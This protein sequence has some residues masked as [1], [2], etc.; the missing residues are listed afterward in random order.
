M[1]LGLLSII[2]LLAIGTLNSVFLI[3]K[4]GLGY[5]PN[6]MLGWSLLLYNLFILTY[7]LW[8]EAGYI[9]NMPHMLRSFS[10]FMYLCAPFFYFFV[11]NSTYNL[12]GLQK[13]D[14]IHFIPALFHFIDLIPFYLL[15]TEDKLAIAEIIVASPEQVNQIGSGFVP[16]SIH[17]TLRIILQTVYFIASVFLLY[18]VKPHFWTKIDTSKIQNWLFVAILIMGWIVVSN[19]VYVILADIHFFMEKD[20]ESVLKFT[21][22]SSLAGIFFLNIYINFKPELVYQFD[23][24]DHFKGEMLQT[25]KISPNKIL[26]ANSNNRS[27]E[28]NSDLEEIKLN[29]PCVENLKTLLENEN[30]YLEKNLSLALLSEKVG[31]SQK[32][33][34]ALFK[35]AYGKKFSE[36][37]NEMRVNFAVEKIEDGYLDQFTLESLRE[38]VGYTSR[39]TFFNAFKKSKGCSPNE[40]WKEFQNGA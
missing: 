25:T 5:H 14:W 15:P 37:I 26:P 16:I 20:M 19:L 30:L 34:S 33:I 29:D 1:S 40:Y 27:D 7:F 35:T 4:K 31:T 17:Y 39:T 18:K 9:L 11:R 13:W 21:V 10:P 32:N 3:V 23:P 12:Q 22:L 8:F 2:V 38:K 24:E 36:V 28:P 6:T